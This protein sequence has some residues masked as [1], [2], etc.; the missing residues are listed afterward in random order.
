MVATEVGMLK[1]HMEEVVGMV[2]VICKVTDRGVT[3][4]ALIIVHL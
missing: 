2:A 1:V 4:A 3:T